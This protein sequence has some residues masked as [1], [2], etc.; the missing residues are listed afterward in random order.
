LA[1]Y[2]Q[3]IEKPRLSQWQHYS[4]HTRHHH[5]PSP[6]PP[7]PPSLMAVNKRTDTMQAQTT[8]SLFGPQVSFFRFIFC[9]YQLTSHILSQGVCHCP[10]AP[11]TTLSTPRDAACSGGGGAVSMGVALHVVIVVNAQGGM[12]LPSPPLIASILPSPLYHSRSTPFHPTSN[13]LWQ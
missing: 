11:R 6:P 13:C 8:Q 10:R 7:Q 1:C 9:F 5:S 2:G 3:F 4:T 12:F